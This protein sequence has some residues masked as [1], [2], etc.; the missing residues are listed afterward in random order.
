MVSIFLLLALVVGG[1]PALRRDFFFSDRALGWLAGSSGSERDP[2]SSP[3]AV[4]WA[5][6]QVPPVLGVVWESATRGQ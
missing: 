3:I 2:S 6:P 1:V 5:M 4:S